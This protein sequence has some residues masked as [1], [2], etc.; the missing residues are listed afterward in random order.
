MHALVGHPRQPRDLTHSQPSLMR[1]PDRVVALL[2][3]PLPIRVNAADLLAQLHEF[4]PNRLIV[5]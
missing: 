4:R 5:R 2:A 3:Q 1:R